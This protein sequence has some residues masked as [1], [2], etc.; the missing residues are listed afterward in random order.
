MSFGN[1]SS[2][3]TGYFCDLR[4]SAENLTGAGAS[5]TPDERFA[6][7]EAAGVLEDLDLEFDIPSHRRRQLDKFLDRSGFRCGLRREE[8]RLVCVLE[9]RHLVTHSRK[10]A[11]RDRSSF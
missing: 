7:V 3:G 2:A 4:I 10:R 5:K 11:G 8:R 6:D 9:P 1:D